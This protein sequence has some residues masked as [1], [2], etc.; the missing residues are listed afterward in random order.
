M[1]NRFTKK[2]EM[3]IS[4]SKKCA[5]AL[6]SPYIGTEHLLL[7]ILDVDCVG[8]KI[9]EDKRIY[10]KEIFLRLNESSPPLEISLLTDELSPK[11]KRVIETSGA[12]AKK[13]NS[14]LI[15]TEHLLYALCEEN[16]SVGAKILISSGISLH[17]L[18]NDISA[19][20]DS[21]TKSERQDKVQ[22]QGCPV[23]STYGRNL[24]IQAR[25]G[26]YD[27]LIGRENEV[28]RL[29]QILSRR[30]KNNPCLIGEPGV[31][32]TAI[33]EGLAQKINEADVPTD[34]C[35]KTIVALD[36]SAMIAGAKYR[37]EF[38]ERMRGVLN[39]IRSNP[40]IILFIDEIHT[41]IGAGAAEGAVD[42]ANII[43]PALAR[44][45]VQLIGATT[46]SE[47]RKHIE[48]DSALERRFQPI[49]VEEPT[50]EKA[51][52]ILFGLKS[53]YEDFHGVK[54]SDEAIHASISLS[55]RYIND[56]YL[57][58]KAIDLI[59]EG[60]SY[61]KL[62]R[63]SK[64]PEIRELE[65][66]IQDLEK[67]RESYVVNEDFDSAF[68][69][70][71]K[72]QSLKIELKNA[73]KKRETSLSSSTPVLTENDIAE[74]VTKW[75]QIPLGDLTSSE[76]EKLKNLEYSLKKNIIGQDDAISLICA[77]IKRS[78]MGL[79]NPDRPVGS[80][81]LLGPT[82]VGKTE[83]AR[84]LARELFGSPDSLIR[85]DMSE[86]MEKHSVSRLVGSPPGYIGYDEGGQLTSKVRLKP[87]SVVLFD[88][89][90]KA[91]KDIYNILLQILDSGT[92]TDSKGR[93]IS[94]KNTIIILTSNIG[95]RDIAE[96]HS[97]GFTESSFNNS[98][99]SKSKIDD[100]L[101]KEFSPE[102]LNRLDEI[103][104]FNKL[105]L[106]DIKEI[107]S[108]MLKELKSLSKSIGITIELDNSLV[109]YI[110]KK[111][112]SDTYGARPIR[113][114]ITTLIENPLS[115]KILINEIKAGDSVLINSDGDSVLFKV[116]QS[117]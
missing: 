4:S 10:Y 57:P 56:R 74:V 92:L 33:V 46:I 32:K 87:Y 68:A 20:L 113:R 83:L 53:N 38:E 13:F 3:V 111:S 95:A 81:M 45:Q 102:F 98:S 72:L 110:C 41:I 65:K 86:Y 70:K 117:V 60:C 21:F 84:C 2:A 24:N 26:K 101:K 35:N 85:L 30:T 105:K 40:N 80:F 42:A 108:I 11:F 109:D 52:D 100:A 88:E 51:L 76:G 91:H 9:L 44:S 78:K 12:I 104:I 50:Q 90:E 107:C 34:L 82:G 49:L 77:S 25:L 106:D 16:D 39:E 36:L 73:L 89:I 1:L 37:G 99:L 64:T 27:P 28:D 96:K 67:E 47:Y 112:F 8:C 55:K 31:G 58:D 29:I 59:D 116:N 61:I 18:K 62:K 66:R 63:S 93:S 48:K 71:D 69:L 75:T 5:Q 22:V 94:F 7:G 14:S 15:G 115:E 43:K 79:K 103:V 114:A 54:I 23:L 17:L 19:Y 97:L 6:G